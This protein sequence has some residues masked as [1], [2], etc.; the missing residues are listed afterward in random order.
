MNATPAARHR[1]SAAEDGLARFVRGVRNYPMLDKETEAA[2]I[3]RWRGSR[4]PDALEQLV[5]SHQRLVIK[6]ATDYRGYDMPLADLISEGN[7]GLM[8]AL[9]RFDPERGFRL[10]TYAMWWIRT[11]I[12]DYVLRS[13]SLV[14]TITNAHRKKLF[15][16]LRRMK[17]KHQGPRNGALAAEGVAAIARELDVP[18][19]EIVLMDHWFDSR[20]RSINAELGDESGA[21]WQ[22]MLADDAMDPEARA[23]EHDTDKKRRALLQDAL[24]TLDARERRIVVERKLSDDPPALNELSAVYGISRERVRQIE[25]RAL[26]KIQAFIRNSSRVSDVLGC[27]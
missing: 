4:D 8:Q 19:S 3:G 5:G 17:A 6:I 24:A 7:V 23:I 27:A 16:N 26:E 15:F 18:E 9:E 25:C 12:S 20:D 22:D 1:R 13:S 11:G 14:K 10:S 21:T 2:L